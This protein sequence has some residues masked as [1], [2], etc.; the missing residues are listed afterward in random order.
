MLCSECSDGYSEALY[1]TSS[2]KKDK[3]KDHWFWL[4]TVIYVVIFAAYFVYK[5]P[6]YS[7][8]CKETLWFKKMTINTLIQPP[9]PKEGEE[10]DSGYLNIV[11]FFTFTK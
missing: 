1:S 7:R 5:P 6:V 8:L 11:F 2:R 3:C 9:T 4:V 10:L